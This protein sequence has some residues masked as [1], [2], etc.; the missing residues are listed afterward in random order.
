MRALGKRA[1][2]GLG[3]LPRAP[4]A[5]RALPLHAEF[6]HSLVCVPQGGLGSEPPSPVPALS[7]DRAVCRL[8]GVR[9]RI[10]M[11]KIRPR[12]YARGREAPLAR[13]G[14][15]P[16]LRPR[17]LTEGEMGPPLRSGR[18]CG[19][20]RTASMPMGDCASNAKRLTQSATSSS[21]SSAAKALTRPISKS[22]AAMTRS[23]SA[24][25]RR[26]R[27]HPKA[28]ISPFRQ[29]RN[30]KTTAIRRLAGTAPR[31]AP[32]LSGGPVSR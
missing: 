28:D 20:G 30:P 8:A 2:T 29:A 15:L 7:R 18:N 9:A 13:G 11:S 31:S 6:D 4:R 12:H 32:A 1:K 27:V 25:I 10:S 16:G 21:S 14:S 3:A 24:I 23:P 26:E 5:E 17:T 22:R 19:R